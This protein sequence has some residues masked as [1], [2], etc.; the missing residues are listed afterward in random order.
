MFHA[1]AHPKTFPKAIA[2]RLVSALEAGGSI[3]LFAVLD[4][5]REL[6]ADGLLDSE[7]IGRLN[8]PLAELCQQTGYALIDPVGAEAGLVSFVRRNCVRLARVLAETGV[9]G[10][11]AEA[12]LALAADDP[13]PEV[14][15]ALTTAE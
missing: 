7:Q 11:G 5:V 9:S 2:E 6:V 3:G 14:R 10:P 8:G 13:L 4:A 12:W 15:Y 1:A